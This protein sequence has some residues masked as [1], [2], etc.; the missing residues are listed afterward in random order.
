MT[1]V[2]QDPATRDPATRDRAGCPV[3]LDPASPAFAADPFPF[4]AQVRAH[5]AATEVDLAN[6]TTAWFVTAHG[7]AKNV[8]TD[9][10]F[11]AAPPRKDRQAARAG[12]EDHMLNSD[13]ARH[14]RLRRMVARTFGPAAVEALRPR[15]EALADEL[16]DEL[17]V[18]EGPT[19]L[20]SAYAFP[21][22]VFVMCEVL[23][24]PPVDRDALRGW[25]YAVSAPKAAAGPEAVA[26]AWADMHAYFAGLIAEKRRA[27]GTDLFSA[28]V[29]AHDAE[30]ALTDSELLSMAFL[31]LFAGYETTMNL[32]AGGT[33]TLLTDPA[34]R[35][36]VATGETSWATCV[37]EL[38][39]LV[40]PLEG[41]T[42][43]FATQ[44]VAVG[45]ATVPAG[46]SVLVS[47]AGANHDPAV[48]EDPEGF[49]P[50]RDGP[51]HLAFGHGIHVCVGAR[52]A[53]LEAE[54]AF[55][56]LFERFGHL[57]L[58]ASAEE[59]PWRP[60]LLVRG[61]RVLP[62]RLDDPLAGL[63]GRL[64]A[65]EGKGLRR[66]LTPRA[67]DDD[68]LDLASNDYLGLTRDPRVIAAAVEAAQRW[69]GGATGSRLVTGTTELHAEL[70]QALAEHCGA[71]AALV[72]SSGYLANLAAV[73]AL[74]GEGALVV[75]D[76]LNHASIV[77]AC[78]LSRART[79]VAPHRDV[80]AMERLL[81]ERSQGQAVL[82]TDAIFSVDGESAPLTRLAAACRRQGALLVVDEAHALGV[83]GVAGQGGAWAAG[84]AGA[85]DV[86]LTLTLSKSL[87]SQGGAV[88]G[89]RAV[90]DHLVS[91][92]RPFIFDTGLAPA[93]AGAAL[94]A[95]RVLRAEPERAS[96]ARATAE[97][98]A[99]VARGLGL[100]ASDPEAAVLSIR[101][102]APAR[103]LAAA[104][105][106]LAHGVRVGCFRPPS[107][108]DADSRL[109]VTARAD[110]TEA[111]VARLV[112]ALAA[113]AE[114]A[115]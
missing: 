65:I 107:V 86:V 23:G 58:A 94:G 10:R 27:P 102:G 2:R 72:F 99:D 76:A 110:L 53:R 79:A 80:E 29:H 19:D 74:A 50:E 83:V 51:R 77:D 89:D 101:M 14:A 21:L 42:W 68:V 104:Q 7:D 71:S 91:T 13:G 113:V 44:D 16:L 54:I 87:G 37:E 57:R 40:S 115:G 114:Q 56:R 35:G 45:E 9:A 70:E 12:L 6:G 36:R 34:Q 49:D 96:L 81:A 93:A 15:I 73:T 100:E 22:P 62:V 26:Q 105:T 11:S 39:R 88:V 5:G 98:L 1:E 59:L 43:R 108:P 66:R 20:V 92:A 3:H 75:S 8:L 24:V 106:C 63:R 38:L 111:D 48:Y 52:L 64:A 4:Y 67:A 103:A 47:L 31:L 97:R 84:L 95:L 33:L 69:G 41:A 25:T 32:L 46:A 112:R 61:P 18:A 30:G 85:P 28:L 90:I 55:S 82:V 78:R 109:R 60:G 17:A